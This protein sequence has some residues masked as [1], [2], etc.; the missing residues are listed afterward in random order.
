MKRENKY[1]VIDFSNHATIKDG[2][3][4]ALEPGEPLPSL[5]KNLNIF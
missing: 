1:G 5:I 4:F 3:V 2:Y